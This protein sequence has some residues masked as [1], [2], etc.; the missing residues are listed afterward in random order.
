MEKLE[1][2]GGPVDIVH[3]MREEGVTRFI[4]YSGHTE[5]TALKHLAESYDFDTMLMALNHYNP[6]TGFIE[7]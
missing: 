3:R 5:A 1:A 2:K 7:T 6:G 4:G